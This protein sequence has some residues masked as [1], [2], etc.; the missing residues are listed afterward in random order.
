[1]NASGRNPASRYVVTL[2]TGP[3]LRFESL[4][5]SGAT[6]SGRC[7]NCGGVPRGFK[8]QN[9]LES[10]GEMVLS[11]DDVADASDRHRP[12]RMP[13]DR[14]AC[15]R[16]RSKAKS[17]MSAV[18]LVCSP[19]TASVNATV[20]RFAGH[21]KAQS[22]RL[23]SGSAAVAFFAGQFRMSALNSHVPC[24]PDFS[25]VSGMRGGEV[26]V[27]QCLFENLPRPF[28]GEASS[29]SDCLYSS[30]QFSPSHF[31]PS[32]I[33]LTR[34]LGVALDVGIVEAKNHG[35]PLCRA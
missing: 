2:T 15:R 31:R 22:K 14:S 6:N 24:V 35:A 18:A 5:P 9:M 4:V 23:A 13:S 16:E 21:A 28:C 32:K 26:A 10:V 30:S 8:D 3:C 7:A 1:M 29:R 25:A 11:A 27:G 20:S 12:H 17:S 19:Y 34:S 33:E